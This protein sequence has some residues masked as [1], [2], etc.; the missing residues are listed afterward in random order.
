[1]ENFSGWF[2]Y[3][4]CDTFNK[5]HKM[6]TIEVLTSQP[7][8][9]N[10]AMPATV[11]FGDIHGLTFWKKVVA[12][13][14]DCR[15][16]FLGDYLDPYEHIAPEQLMNNLKEIIQL[17]KDRPDDVVLLLGNHDLHYFCSDMEPSS[18]F[19]FLIAEEASALFR[20]NIHLFMYAYQINTCIFTHAGISERWFLYDF[21][22]DTTKNIAE[23]LNNPLPEQETSLCRCGEARGGEPGKVGG[24]FWADVSELYKPLQGYTQV[25]GHNRVNDVYEHTNNGGRIIFC[26]CLFNE[27]YLKLE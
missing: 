18:R 6:K 1:M 25:V 21:M 12:E 14:P 15:F 9:D 17:K 10:I 27:K 16:I 19:D 2:W 13:N 8:N 26:D 11:V 7:S 5:R 22:G 24:I 4:I 3:E 23:Q 20:E